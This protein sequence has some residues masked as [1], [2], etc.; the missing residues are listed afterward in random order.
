[1]GLTIPQIRQ[2]VAARIIAGMT[3]WS[4]SDLPLEM[5][6]IEPATLM[7]K[8]FV[9]W[10][11]QNDNTHGIQG[12]RGQGI[13]AEEALTIR[14]SWKIPP[15]DKLAARDSS[16]AELCALIELLTVQKDGWPGQMSIHYMGAVPTTNAA[17]E[18]YLTDVNFTIQHVLAFS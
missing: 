4:Q 3:G 10:I 8:R 1:M 5:F 2:N 18:Y 11:K 12:R 16:D 6:G 9:C 7:H 17:A 13:Y 14:F 15:K